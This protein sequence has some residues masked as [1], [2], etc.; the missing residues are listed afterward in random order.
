VKWEKDRGKNPKGTERH[1]NIHH[2]LDQKQ[3]A[4]TGSTS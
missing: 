1:N 3:A 2:T 4:R